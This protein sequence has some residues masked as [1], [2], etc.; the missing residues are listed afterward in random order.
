MTDALRAGGRDGVGDVEGE[1]VGRHQPDPQ[2]ARVQR[3]RDFLRGVRLPGQEADRLHVLAIVRARDAVVLRS[4][5]VECGNAPVGAHQRRREGGVGDDSFLRAV[6]ID[7]RDVAIA[8]L[9]GGLGL[10]GPS[11]EEIVDRCCWCATRSRSSRRRSDHRHGR[12]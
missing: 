1:V 5:E 7:L 2:F 12:A 4:D 8:D 9:A 6:A 11:L 10:C 3:D